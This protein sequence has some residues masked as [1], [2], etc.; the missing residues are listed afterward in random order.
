M[1]AKLKLLEKKINFGT[2]KI[3]PGHEEGV[4]KILQMNN[5][6]ECSLN[7]DFSYKNFTVFKSIYCSHYKS[8][9]KRVFSNLIPRFIK[10]VIVNIFF[11]VV[12]SYVQ[13]MNF[14]IKKRTILQRLYRIL[15]Q[16]DSQIIRSGIFAALL[17]ALL[18]FF[19]CL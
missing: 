15:V 3:Y 17:G 19:N 16:W 13:D 5:V 14:R 2:S 9:Y 11:K 12:L 6:P 7:E 4:T 18:N 10:G 1:Q 8:C